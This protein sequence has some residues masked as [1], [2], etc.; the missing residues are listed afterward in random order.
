MSVTPGAAADPHTAVVAETWA[1]MLELIDKFADF[2][3]PAEAIQIS[4]AEAV[5]SLTIKLRRFDAIR[6]IEVAR[7]AFLPITPAGHMAISAEAGAANVE[8]LALVALAAK[9]HAPSEETQ[10][11][12]VEP[13]EM[14]AV[15][16]E[17]KEDLAAL[18]RLAQFRSAAQADPTDKMSLV[19]LLIQGSE[20]SVR[21]LS[22]PEMV[23][24]TNLALLDGE[25][26]VRAALRAELGFEAGE[27]LAVLNACHELQM[28]SLN[29]RG[30]AM[31][32]TMSAATASAEGKEPDPELLERAGEVFNSVFEPESVDATV[33]FDELVKYTGIPESRVRAVIERFR[34]D[35]GASS[36]ADVVDAFVTG[37]NPLRSRPL[38][39]TAGERVMLPHN[40]LN[41][42]ALRENLEEYLKTTRIWETYARHRGNL[43][44]VRTRVALKRVL[45]GA[46]F[47]DAFEYYVPDNEDQENGQDP[48]KYTKRVEG[49]HLVTLDDVAIVVEDKA[50]AL[51]ALSRGGKTR[52]IRT[53][54]TGIITK[55]AEQAGRMRDRIE[56]DG[57]L[58]IQG[59]GWVDLG[60]I[61]EIHTIAVSLDDLSSV[62]TVTAH[63]IDAGLLTIDNIPWTVSIH[64]LELITELVERPAEFLLY[65]R[66]RRDP[67]VTIMFSAPDELDLFLYY[68]EAGLYVEPDPQG[69][70]AAFPF[71]P[72]PST[73]DL[74]RYRSQD[75]VFVTS[76]TDPLDQW[77]YS[78][79]REGTASAPKPSM[80]PSPVGTLIDELQARQVTGWLSVGATLLS[81]ST[82]AQHQFARNG[83]DLLDKPAANGRGRSWA[84]PLTATV[85]RAEGWLL[86]WATRPAH[87][88]ERNAEAHSRD[89]LRAKKYQLGVPRGVVFMYDESTRKLAGMYYDGHA[90]PLDPALAP[91]FDSLRPPSDLTNRLPPSAKRPKPIPKSS[92]RKKRP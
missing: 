27:A 38:I 14:I 47:R 65:L 8:L 39:V 76:R 44:E 57:G 74:R 30:Q 22:Y 86:V 66:R 24:K 78:T 28:S 50:V 73:A 52:R 40:A 34:L 41:T 68:F 23:T 54:L 25:P 71:L 53:D 11:K 61:R 62:L 67:N 6:L 31:A 36:V 92:K 7:L 33:P 1:A 9:T 70:N 58:R 20:V 46:T 42:F 87:E 5:N 75:P 45:P 21:N 60:H 2:D 89:Y 56:C 80:T 59:E 72:A 90:G 17:A 77:F 82:K 63:L 81:G 12:S 55:A 29:A 51:S 16:A 19:S 26:R 37:N 85:N 48:T 79:K 18:V 43:L 3:A 10:R 88:S 84:T 13:R 69:V 15:V 4:F 32:A 83:K 35:I 91:I 64:D 49:D